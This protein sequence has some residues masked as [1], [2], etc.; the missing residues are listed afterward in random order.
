LRI[1]L[2]QMIAAVEE[3]DQCV[4]AL[5]YYAGLRLGELRALR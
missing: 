4:W 3:R 2:S 1:T 5:A